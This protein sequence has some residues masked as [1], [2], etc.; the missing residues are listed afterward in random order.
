[1]EL[2][3]VDNGHAYVLHVDRDASDG[4]LVAT[5]NLPDRQPRFAANRARQRHRFCRRRPVGWVRRNQHHRPIAHDRFDLLLPEEDVIGTAGRLQ[6]DALVGHTQVPF[7]VTFDERIPAHLH[8]AT[9][10]SKGNSGLVGVSVLG[11]FKRINALATNGRV[12]IDTCRWQRLEFN[13]SCRVRGENRVRDCGRSI[14]A[15]SL[16]GGEWRRLVVEEDQA[17]EQQRGDE[18]E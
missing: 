6:F 7:V 3:L 11:S 12:A 13:R 9:G 8:P 15:Q 14:T 2:V 18:R 17:Y 16:I 4:A 1:M 10:D 5:E